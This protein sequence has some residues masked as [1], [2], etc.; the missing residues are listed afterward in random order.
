M[1]IALYRAELDQLDQELARL[2]GKRARI[3][4]SIGRMKARTG[5][6]PGDR[7][8]EQDV[9]SQFVARAVSDGYPPAE[10]WKVVTEYLRV[11]RALVEEEVTAAT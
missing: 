4:Q 9:V 8:R 10:A 5:M 3:A 6:P 1:T 7:L 11:C 2:L